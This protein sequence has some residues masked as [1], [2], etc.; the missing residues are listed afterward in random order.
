MCRSQI[1]GQ[2]S[3]NFEQLRPRPPLAVAT[4]VGSYGCPDTSYTLQVQPPTLPVL[5][6]AVKL[7]MLILHFARPD[8]S[9][10]LR[11]PCWVC[12]CLQFAI[13]TLVVFRKLV[14]LL[15]VNC[16]PPNFQSSCQWTVWSVVFCTYMMTFEMWD[17]CS[18]VFE[19][20]SLQQTIYIWSAHRHKIISV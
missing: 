11:W 9:N 6:C 16:P 18:K 7:C 19:M 2:N 8:N 10:T 15:L 3:F 1:Q 4:L 5:L 13:F 17:C 20:K 14:C 12:R